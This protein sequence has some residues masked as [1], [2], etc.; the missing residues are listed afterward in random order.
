[1][2]TLS[3]S[4]APGSAM[5]RGGKEQRR[6]QLGKRVDGYVSRASA[7]DL[8]SIRSGELARRAPEVAREAR[9]IVERERAAAQAGIA[10]DGVVPVDAAQDRVM[11]LGV[12]ELL[13]GADKLLAAHTLA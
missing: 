10:R 5:G 7:G 11:Q 13:R 3:F 6:Q 12:D 4:G 8:R 2:K 9:P 1:M